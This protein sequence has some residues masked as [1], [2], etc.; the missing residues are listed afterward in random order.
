M[1]AHRRSQ[2]TTQATPTQD[3]LGPEL[4]PGFLEM[5]GNQ[6]VM[7]L[8]GWEPE[9]MAPAPMESE[10]AEGAEVAPAGAE[11]AGP[12]ADAP[13]RIDGKSGYVYVQAPDGAI[14]IVEGPTSVG[15]TVR[16]GTAWE[17]ITNEIGPY[18]AGGGEVVLDE[19]PIIP[20]ILRQ[21]EALGVQVPAE[22]S[23]DGEIDVEGDGPAV[24]FSAPDGDW[25]NPRTAYATLSDRDRGIYDRIEA[26]GEPTADL[27]NGIADE[28]LYAMYPEYPSNVPFGELTEGD[29]SQAFIAAILAEAK[30]NSTGKSDFEFVK[31]WCIDSWLVIRKDWLD[32][33]LDAWHLDHAGHDFRNSEASTTGVVGGAQQE[34]LK[35]SLLWD[36]ESGQWVRPTLEGAT[37]EEMMASV[38][39]NYGSYHNTGMEY[40]KAGCFESASSTTSEMGFSDSGKYELGRVQVAEDGGSMYDGENRLRRQEDR[41]KVR[42][43]LVEELSGGN[44]VIVG[45]NYTN[46]TANQDGTDHWITVVAMGVDPESGSEVFFA[47]ENAIGVKAFDED[48]GEAVRQGYVVALTIDAQGH[49]KHGRYGG[50]DA[51]NSFSYDDHYVI[52]VR[53]QNRAHP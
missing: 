31:Q 44:P 24:A 18:T 20:D 23:G 37:M 15:A 14:T 43:I 51:D 32:G 42:Q 2:A 39:A 16:S 10:Q 25:V 47:L 48:R 50:H 41:D 35:A 29:V 6:W 17:A 3:P 12:V 11:G 7:E 26:K 53:R 1:P 19:A 5:M 49:I 33:P 36:P 45:V 13:R 4:S 30:G 52:Q 22:G 8:L 21:V 28:Q 40:G 34:D 46:E 38:Q 9:T 27:L